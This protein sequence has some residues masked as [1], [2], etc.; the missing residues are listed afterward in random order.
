[1]FTGIVQARVQLES[2]IIKPG[3]VSLGLVLPRECSVGVNIGASIAIDGVCLTVTAFDVKTLQV[4]FDVIRQTLNVTSLSALQV[5]DWVNIERSAK[6]SDEIGGHHVSGH[7]DAVVE[8]VAID[9]EENNQRVSYRYPSDYDAYLF[10]KGFVA[11]NGCSLTIASMH[12]SSSLLT[13]CYIP[14][15]LRATNHGLKKVGDKVNLE[16]DRQTQA[17]V[18]T[19]ERILAQRAL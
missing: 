4:S 2:V 16:L 13:V 14:E 8:I 11:L 12:R 17:I 3:L 10:D 7:C 15:T 5:G 19:V 6:M 9:V 18:D 1:M